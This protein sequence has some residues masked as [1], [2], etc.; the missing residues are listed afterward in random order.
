[1]EICI[2]FELRCFPRMLI[3]YFFALHH[4]RMVYEIPTFI[5]LNYTEIA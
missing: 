2:Q 5:I 4:N 3:T 1:M